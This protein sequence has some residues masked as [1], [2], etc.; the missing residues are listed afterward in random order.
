MNQYCYTILEG[1]SSEEN[2]KKF[3]TDLYTNTKFENHFTPDET[4]PFVILF[5][6]QNQA[7]VQLKTVAK[8]KI[9]RIESIHSQL[10]SKNLSKKG[11]KLS[12]PSLV[13]LEQCEWWNEDCPVAGEKWKTLE[14][15]GPYFTHLMEP[16]QPHKSGIVYAGKKYSLNPVE[17]RVLGFYAKRI[18]SESKGNIAQIWTKDPVF[19][20]NF[21]ND[22]KEYL[23]PEHRKIFTDMK[24]FKFDGMIDAIE[25]VKKQSET[26][27]AKAV[28][29]A[30][31]AQRKAKYGFAI[32]N[33]NKEPLGNFIVEPASIF[34]GRG[35]NPQRGKIK[36]DVEPEEVTINI[37]VEAK[38]PE[39]P[40]GHKW[41]KVVHD[42]NLAWIANWK[43]TIS[44]EAKY[45]Y[46]AAEGQLKGKSDLIKYEK[47]RKLNR[48][49]KNVV[50]KYT[51]DMTSSDEAVKQLGTVLY[52]I[53]NF[54]I[55]VG[56][57]KDTD[58]E[59]D[60]VGASTLR[61]EHIKL[62]NPNI[63]IFDFLGKD[64][65]RFYKE[66]KVTKQVFENIKSL[67]T[68][69]AKTAQLFDKI[70][71][72]DINAYLKSIDKD[73]SAKV[74]R[75][76]LASDQ[77]T[78]L[79]SQNVPKK[80]DSAAE[81]KRI[82]LKANI[83]VAETMNHIKTVTAKQQESI[84]KQRK[85]IE[86][87]EGQLEA[88]P[89]VKAREALE[90][91]IDKK[92]E[93]L[94]TKSSTTNVAVNTSLV[95]YID[96]RLVVAWALKYKLDID[97]LY[98]KTLMKKFKWAI[99]ST[100]IDWDYNKT[101]LLPSMAQ[102]A[103]EVA[104]KKTTRTPGTKSEVV[105]QTKATSKTL[106]KTLGK[107]APAKKSRPV[108]VGTPTP[109]PVE[110]KPPQ[111]S[112]VEDKSPS[113]IIDTGKIRVYEY[114][115]KAVAVVG[116]TKPLKDEFRQLGGKYSTSVAINGVKQP[117]WFFS[118]KKIP[119]LQALLVGKLVHT[120]IHGIKI[121]EIHDKY[122]VDAPTDVGI[123]K[124]MTT[125]LYEL[126]DKKKLPK[127]LEQ[128]RAYQD[129]HL[130]SPYGSDSLPTPQQDVLLVQAPEIR[131]Y[132]H[133]KKKGYFIV[134]TLTRNYDLDFQQAKGEQTRV[135]DIPNLVWVFPNRKLDYI[136]K[137]TGQ[138]DTD[139]S[140]KLFPA[141]I[142]NY[143]PKSVAIIGDYFK[144]KSQLGKFYPFESDKIQYNDK[145]YSGLIFSRKHYAQLRKIIP[146]EA[147]IPQEQQE[148]Q[149]PTIKF[150][151][152]GSD[153]VLLSGETDI[154]L[155][156]LVKHGTITEQGD[157]LI[158]AHLKPEIKK[159]LE[160]N[161]EA[162]SEYLIDI[163]TLDKLREISKKPDTFTKFEIGLQQD[164][165]F[166]NIVR[167]TLA[168]TILCITDKNLKLVENYAS[169]M[170]KGDP[171]ITFV[172]KKTLEKM[173]NNPEIGYLFLLKLYSYLDPDLGSQFINLLLE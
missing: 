122:Y 129:H 32:I 151:Q 135:E 63:V 98:S 160:E 46:F 2:V 43:D 9:E 81:K 52:L 170:F 132:N 94:E 58:A 112:P 29:E 90:K 28:K 45:V 22:L 136:K 20:N 169:A 7:C 140:D 27:E 121:Y 17:E 147:L 156:Y 120:F 68:G 74:F 16:Y 137:L 49:H 154:L 89:T 166:S 59:A 149:E 61:V 100:P 162:D 138:K 38:I 83:E 70:T 144:Y 115:E 24:K 125:P 163:E 10:N 152:H 87:L 26:K 93:A 128:L 13:I 95:N 65:V 110:H 47:A 33:G 107:T 5:N 167:K 127:I 35:E 4:L 15:R 14:H 104:G 145:I 101:D 73:F 118:K 85:Q 11:I 111:Q 62:K 23:T 50:D 40:A 60:T 113:A 133:P 148:Q 69:R 168:Q 161:S 21:F 42:R 3:I 126:F 31:N 108:L 66:L 80:T 119:E 48:F 88:A 12:P 130:F 55:R 99:D 172:T 78:K 39:P 37:G 1:S 171:G 51:R 116:D 103:P 86:E 6:D 155:K 109:S 159:L 106:A 173:K 123:E 76:R 36:K 114:S 41:K 8:K 139:D 56:N 141:I 131:I 19:N 67:L 25:E 71:A 53:D 142:I 75:T 102:L 92:K 34:Y 124:F 134:D 84:E 30:A 18:I 77:M 157:W 44:N 82:F 153:Q 91:R 64:S 158:P 96:P 57:E 143:S 79:L 146:D 72:N 165:N 54:G 97:K 105:R 164:T 150:R 117:G